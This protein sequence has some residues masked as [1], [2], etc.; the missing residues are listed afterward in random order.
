MDYLIL[1]LLW[2]IYF[3]IHSALASDQVKTYYARIIKRGFRF[4]RIIYSVISILGLLAILVF[5]ASITSVVLFENKG[6]IRYIS[7]MLATFG[8]IIISRSFREYRFAAFVGLKE[9]GNE[10]I[11]TGILKYVRHPIYSGT[12]LLVVGFF[13]FI[14]TLSSLISACCTLA[15]LPVGIYLEERK[16]INQF[17]DRYLTYKKEVPSIFPRLRR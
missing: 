3:V 11:K 13:L 2:L 10:F 14:P 4:Y 5:N 6:W 15:Y 1:S 12:I 17:G 7:M 9:E 16:L 8:V